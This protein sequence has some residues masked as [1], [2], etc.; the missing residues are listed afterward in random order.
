MIGSHPLV[1]NRSPE[2]VGSGEDYAC[3]IRRPLMPINLN[4]G[5]D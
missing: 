2:Q 3:G 5:I 4:T 1:S